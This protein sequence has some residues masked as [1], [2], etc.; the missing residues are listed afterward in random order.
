MDRA[1]FNEKEKILPLQNQEP[2]LPSRRLAERRRASQSVA[3]W[4]P[5]PC[6]RDHAPCC[7]EMQKI[8][9]KIEGF[10]E[11]VRNFRSGPKFKA[12]SPQSPGR[13]GRPLPLVY[14]RLRDT[15]TGFLTSE[16]TCERFLFFCLDSGSSFLSAVLLEVAGPVSKHLLVGFV[17]RTR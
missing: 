15:C 9:V 10:R 12:L 3:T 11:D 14:F 17:L 6:H 8:R 16:Q 2:M 4:V 7:Q 13:P 5:F 1:A